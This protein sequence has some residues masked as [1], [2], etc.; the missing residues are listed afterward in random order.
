MVAADL[1]LDA[2]D[3]TVSLGLAEMACRLGE[4][5]DFRAAAGHLERL[6]QVKLSPEK[7]RELTLG[8]GEAVRAAEKAGTAPPPDWSAGEC[9]VEGTAITRMY[10]GADGV[11]VPTVTE[12]EKRARRK[13]VRARRAKCGRKRRPLPRLGKGTD[14]RWKEAKLVV[15]YDQDRERRLVSAAVEDAAA[16]GRRMRRDAKRIRL[17][18]ADDRLG[19]FDGADWIRNQVR[20]Q[21]LPLDGLRAGLLPPRR[22]RPRLPARGLR[23][24]RRPRRPGHDLGR[25]SAARREARRL[26]RPVGPPGRPAGL[27]PQEPTEKGGGRPGDAVRRRAEGDDRLPGLDRRRPRRRQR[28]DRGHVQGRDRPAQGPRHALGPRQRRCHDGPHLPAPLGPLEGLVDLPPVGLITRKASQTPR[29]AT[30]GSTGAP[31]RN[32]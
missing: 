26:R 5:G 13:K 30:A 24:R 19:V 2:A 11:K 16:C 8:E 6:V 18:K 15:F 17:D 14:Q 28:P 3:E 32:G 29:R 7:M 27:G 12:A 9:L 4:A 21:S 20:R 23:R 25:R 10:L 1:R 31:L 22:E